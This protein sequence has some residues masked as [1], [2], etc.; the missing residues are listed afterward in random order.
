MLRNTDSLTWIKSPYCSAEGCLCAAA[1]PDG[2]IK[3]R[4]DKDPSS[5]WL[6]FTETQWNNGSGLAFEP[7]GRNDV[8]H[9]ALDLKPSVDTWFS[10]ADAS[11]RKLWFTED[12]FTEF[13]AGA[14]DGSF[15]VGALTA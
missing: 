7:A 14:R 3:V 15:E 1:D 6:T 10:L 12:E 13:L 2:S 4:D 5:P 11:G 8:P 9:W